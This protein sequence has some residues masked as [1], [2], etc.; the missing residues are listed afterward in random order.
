MIQTAYGTFTG[1]VDL[2]WSVPTAGSWYAAM[3]RLD[4]APNTADVGTERIQ[5]VF[6]SQHGDNYATVLLEEDPS[7]E[8][9]IYLAPDLEVPIS[10]GD[11][12]VVEYTNPAP[13]PASGRTRPTVYV[14]IKGK[15]SLRN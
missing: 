9:D 2:E 4:P 5:V 7:G 12:I 1:E 14:T 3:I 10:R 15:D 13:P 11:R 8:T 6:E